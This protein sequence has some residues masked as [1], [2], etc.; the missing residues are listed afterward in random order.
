MSERER[1]V[2]FNLLGQEY[3]FY[4]GATEQEMEKI[5]SLVRG[6]VEEGT[7][8]TKSGTI[9]AGKAA[10]LACLNIAS[11]YIKLKQDFDNYKNENELK[12]SGLI[13]QIDARLISE[14]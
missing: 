2:R 3:A 10:I 14:K 1:L 7:T 4:T 6:L 11:R 9:P 5:L 8:A 12:A 13:E